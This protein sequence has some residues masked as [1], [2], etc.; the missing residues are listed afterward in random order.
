MEKASRDLSAGGHICHKYLCASHHRNGFC[1][2]RPGKDD[3]AP[4]LQPCRAN[5]IV[6][7]HLRKKDIGWDIGNECG[8]WRAIRKVP[9]VV[10]D[11]PGF[12]VS[13]QLGALMG[14]STFMVGEG[15]DAATI[16]EAVLDFG[17][18]MGPGI[19]SD[20][21]GIDIG[22]HVGRNFEKSFGERWKMSPIY[23][24]VYQTGSYGRKTGAG[25]FD[26]SGEKP[27]PN[28]KVQ[29]VIKKY[30]KEKGVK[31]K[32][33]SPKEIVD[34]M[35]ARAINEASFMIEEGIC[36]RPQDMDLAVIYGLGFPPYRGGICRYADAWGIRNVYEH[37]LKLEKEQGVRFKPAS[38]L[39]EMAE[40]GRNFYGN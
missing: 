4:L 6:R 23:E 25:W 3:R 34:R 10:N 33:L 27:V 19:L 7:D 35:L 11:G 36:D 29:E 37:L 26:Y 28:P 2:E 8:L 15:V 17:L 30:L 20:L 13:R 16:E 38:L 21:T 1:S 31:P 22:Y 39:K 18:P 14:E 32:K 40:S 12:Y 5:A 24:L 9:I